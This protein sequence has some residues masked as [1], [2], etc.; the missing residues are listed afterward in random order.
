MRQLSKHYLHLYNGLSRIRELNQRFQLEWKSKM[1][2]WNLAADEEYARR[3]TETE[4]AREMWDAVR[5]EVRPQKVIGGSL[6]V[7]ALFFVC[8]GLCL[9]TT[10]GGFTRETYAY[11]LGY[12]LILLLGIVIA[13]YGIK[14]KRK[15]TVAERK[16]ASQ[17]MQNPFIDFD[18]KRPR[19]LPNPFPPERRAVPS[20]TEL[21]GLWWKEIEAAAAQDRQ[22]SNYGDI[23]ELDLMNALNR[24]LPN[25]YYAVRGLMVASNLDID[26]LLLG[27]TGI[28]NLESKYFSGQ[29][30]YAD[31]QWRRRKEWVE[32]GLLQYSHEILKDL[33]LQWLRETDLLEKHLRTALPDLPI[34]IKG[35]LVFTLPDVSLQIGHGIPVSAGTTAAWIRKIRA[36]PAD[37]RL[38]EEILLKA[39][40]ALLAISQTHKSQPYRSSVRL[41]NA[42]Y[43][44]QG[45]IMQA[46][47]LKS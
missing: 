34:R 23:G 6:L 40:D 9:L 28:W 41:A 10:S 20:L 39:A 13:F 46:Y 12:S 30:T 3:W 14:L 21:T 29:V 25:S 35:G 44:E 16:A 33:H 19:S 1:T 26:I 43:Q 31:G 37:A 8:P 42:I 17:L 36:E 11:F 38:T 45:E 4:K 7:L 2:R 24:I 32:N 22:P 47:D 15:A 18:P 5:N 27:P